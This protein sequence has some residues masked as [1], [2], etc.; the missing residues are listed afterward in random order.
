MEWYAFCLALKT[1]KCLIQIATITLR[2][3]AVCSC[4]NNH[5][6]TGLISLSEQALKRNAKLHGDEVIPRLLHLAVCRTCTL[7]NYCTFKNSAAA[8]VHFVTYLHRYIQL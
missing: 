7:A 5:T 2:D 3:L 8:R 4:M 6:H 1:R